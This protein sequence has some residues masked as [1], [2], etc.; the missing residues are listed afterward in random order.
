MSSPTVYVVTG[1]TRG[2]GLQLVT[3]LAARPNTVIYAGYRTAPSADSDL[4]QLAAK[5][6][7]VVIPIKLTSGD[8]KDNAA[9]AEVIKAK[10]GKVDV[11]IS[12]AGYCAPLKAIADLTPKDIYS[13]FDINLIGGL[14]LFQNLVPL[15]QA[16]PSPKFIT[17]SSAAGSIALALGVP[18]TSYGISKASANFLAKKI[19]VDYPDI[20][21]FP[22]HASEQ[23]GATLEQ[24][25]A[26][27]PAES[28]TGIL[29]LI[30]K[31]TKETHGGKFWNVDGTELAW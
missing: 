18:I 14:V 27:T 29:S 17:I 2:I 21:S 19:D 20:I 13:E 28:A 26:I 23:L 1:A 15:L 3:Q 7:E 22:L 11:V 16:A 25:G 5:Q 4:A 24:L 12:N 30:D 10:F 6:P 31:A 8:Q 9:A